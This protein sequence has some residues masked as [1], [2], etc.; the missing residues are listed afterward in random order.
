MNSPM[1]LRPCIE[2]AFL[3]LKCVCV[4][5]PDASMTIQVFDTSSEA[6]GFTVTGID[7]AALVTIRDI[8]GLVLEVKGEMRL[9]RLA[10][11]RQQRACKG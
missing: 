1:D 3:P 2:A 6:E 4:I 5:A 10:S 7:T 9:R 11:D 8:V